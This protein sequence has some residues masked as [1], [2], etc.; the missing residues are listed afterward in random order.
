MTVLNTLSIHSKRLLQN[1]TGKYCGTLDGFQHNRLIHSGI[2]CNRSIV[3]TTIPSQYNQYNNI[4]LYTI[5]TRTE[6][7]ARE[8]RKR[9]PIQGT[10]YFDI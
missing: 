3:S 5:S 9:L 4:N 1:R 6:L 2:Y 7:S 8:P 10:S